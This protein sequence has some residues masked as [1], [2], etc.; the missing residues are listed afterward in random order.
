MKIFCI[1]NWLCNTCTLWNTLCNGKYVIP[2]NSPR[3]CIQAVF[4]LAIPTTSVLSTYSRC[5]DNKNEQ[6]EET[7]Q[8]DNNS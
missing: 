5:I 2:T 1:L 3:K 8:I 4:D 7:V 6:L